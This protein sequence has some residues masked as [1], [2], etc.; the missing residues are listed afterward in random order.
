MKAPGRGQGLNVEGAETI[1]LSARRCV[2]LERA[3][4]HRLRHT[5]ITRLQLLLVGLRARPR[6]GSSAGSPYDTSHSM[7]WA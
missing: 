5:S 7:S 6:G 2:G 4:C 3:T 1:F